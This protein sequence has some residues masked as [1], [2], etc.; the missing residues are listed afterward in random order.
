MNLDYLNSLPEEKNK[1]K[2]P[3]EDGEKVV[4][5]A[6]NVTF[7]TEKQRLIGFETKVTVTNRRI[8]A[9]NG[10][11]VWTIDIADDIISCKKV[12]EGKGLMKSVYWAVD[13][14]KSVVCGDPSDPVTLT[15]YVFVFKK[16]DDIRF[17]EIADNVFGGTQ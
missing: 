6:K 13:M 8:F 5:T 14:N 15:G 10:K 1:F 9:D 4:F 17:K 7:G 3:L 11:G 2:V 12:E 16:K